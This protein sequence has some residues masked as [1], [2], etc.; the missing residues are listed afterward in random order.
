MEN[1]RHTGEDNI[2]GMWE[3]RREDATE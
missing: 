1:I 2:C 3:A